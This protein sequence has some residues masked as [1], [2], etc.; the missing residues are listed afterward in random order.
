MRPDAV[1][2]YTVGDNFVSTPN[3]WWIAIVP[4][5]LIEAFESCDGNIAAAARM[6]GLDRANLHR[7]LKRLGLRS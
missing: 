5:S 3:S 7:R 4:V 1:V 6:L 2:I